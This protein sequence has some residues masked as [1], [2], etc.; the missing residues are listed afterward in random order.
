MN[1]IKCDNEQADGE[2]MGKNVADIDDAYLEMER[3]RVVQ[4]W[5]SATVVETYRRKMLS[6]QQQAQAAMK[7]GRVKEAEAI[8]NMEIEKL[9]T[10]GKA[11]N[12]L[13]LSEQLSKKEMERDS[14]GRKRNNLR[15]NKKTSLQGQ[16]PMMLRKFLRG[17]IKMPEALP[18]GMTCFW[19]KK[20]N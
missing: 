18:S 16:L 7:Q 6:L 19:R 17:E 3:L 2:G 14:S 1:P 11:H 9:K 10:R 8:Q 5:G 12:L 20:E 15:S 13:A 4:K